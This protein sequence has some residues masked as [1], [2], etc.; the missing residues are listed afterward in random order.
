[1]P[2]DFGGA[3]DVGDA[4]RNFG[5]VGFLSVREFEG[6][7][8]VTR[9]LEVRRPSEISGAIPV[10]GELGALRRI[11]AHDEYLEAVS[12]KVGAAQC[13]GNALVFGAVNRVGDFVPL[14]GDINLSDSYLY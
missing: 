10:I 8:I 3:V 9:L 2:S 1:M 4:N 7:A 14:G 12:V 6:D 13:E 11:V 5:D